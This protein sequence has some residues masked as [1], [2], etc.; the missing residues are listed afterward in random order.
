MR[1]PYTGPMGESLFDINLS[2]NPEVRTVRRCQKVKKVTFIR[3]RT[4]I[5]RGVRQP[6][7]QCWRRDVHMCDIPVPGCEER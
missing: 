2:G 4:G 3:A 6:T 7:D 1:I 5:T